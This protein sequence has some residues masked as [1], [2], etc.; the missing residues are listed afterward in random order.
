MNRFEVTKPF[1]SPR[2]RTSSGKAWSTQG[3]RHRRHRPSQGS[4]G[5]RLA[6]WTYK[7][8][9]GLSDIKVEADGPAHRPSM[10][11]ADIGDDARIHQDPCR[12]RHRGGGTS[13]QVRNVATIGAASPAPA[14]LVLPPGRYK[15]LKKGGDV[16]YAVGGENRY[17]VIFGGGPSYAVHPRIPRWRSSPFPR[18][19]SSTARKASAPSRRPSSS[20]CLRRTRRWRTRLSRGN[21]H[22]DPRSRGIRP[23]DLR[24]GPRASGLRLAARFHGGDGASSTRAS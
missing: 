20:S 23:V 3:G 21:P 19:S 18:A 22:R 1:T 9:P 13:P 10:K 5:S 12:S 15:C 2:P 8:I 7:G 14:L 4:T 16:C 6:S 17:H 24:R 11:L